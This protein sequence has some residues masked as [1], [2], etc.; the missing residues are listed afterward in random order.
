MKIFRIIFIAIVVSITVLMSGCSGSANTPTSKPYDIYTVNPATPL[1]Y[2]TFYTKYCAVSGLNIL[3]S[4]KPSDASLKYVCYEIDNI[5]RSDKKAAIIAKLIANNIR[6]AIMATTEVTTNIPE[7]ADLNTAYPATNWD[8]CCR[9]LGAT[10]AR[11]AS[12]AA[13]ENITCLSNDPYKG[14]NIFI[15]EFAHTTHLM[16]MN[17]IDSTFDARLQ[18]AYTNAKASGLWTN[19][20]A[21]TNYQEYWAEGV[22]D[23]FN[24]NLSAIPSN[25]IHNEIHTR[26]QLQT[27]DIGLYNLIAEVY[28]TSF[29]P[30]CP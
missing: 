12:S 8:T 27:Y 30:G 2:N 19:T 28:S 18:T 7:H 6:V 11:P 15:H 29:Q 4:S 13:E 21:G 10:L 3:S 5:F 26:A 9:G 22:Q 17:Y 16:A 20:Y 24:V 14:E 1:G 23:W 25:G